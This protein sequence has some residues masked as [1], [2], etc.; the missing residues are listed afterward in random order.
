M[1]G[2]GR[3]KLGQFAESRRGKDRNHACELLKLKD[4][5]ISSN[6]PGESIKLHEVDS[7][8]GDFKIDRLIKMFSG[9]TRER[10][11]AR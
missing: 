3:E 2:V 7:A 9:G 5:L 11:K 10:A 1:E 6:I 8:I 4:D